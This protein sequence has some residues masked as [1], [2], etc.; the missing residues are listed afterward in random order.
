M[1]TEARKKRQRK[2]PHQR[3][4]ERVELAQRAV[5]RA[6]ATLARHDQIRGDLADALAEARER[7]SYAQDDPALAYDTLPT[8]TDEQPPAGNTRPIGD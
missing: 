7:L 1:P 5:D 8:D 3:A 4:T 2:T 6:A